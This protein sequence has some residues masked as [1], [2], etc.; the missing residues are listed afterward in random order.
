MRGDGKGKTTRGGEYAWEGW[1][2]LIPVD[3]ETSRT[4]GSDTKTTL[5][6]TLEPSQRPLVFSQVG[7]EPLKASAIV[8]LHPLLLVLGEHTVLDHL[9]LNGNTGK[10]LETEPTLAVELVFGFDS[11]HDEGGF[12]ADTPLS[13]KI[14]E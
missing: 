4:S 7:F 3:T 1:G 14:C 9:G 5:G 11:S 10:S 8:I 13:G 12:D 2:D 6:L